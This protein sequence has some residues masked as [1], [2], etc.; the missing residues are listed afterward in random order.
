MTQRPWTL[1]EAL[2]RAPTG[3]VQNPKIKD[4]FLRF[5]AAAISAARDGEVKVTEWPAQTT[6]TCAPDSMTLTPDAALRAP[7]S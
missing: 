2:L 4:Y 1:F 3:N 5:F 7:A 6:V